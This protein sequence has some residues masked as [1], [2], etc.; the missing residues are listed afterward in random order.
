MQSISG[1]AEAVSHPQA[2]I[3]TLRAFKNTLAS[4]PALWIGFACICAWPWSCTSATLVHSDAIAIGSPLWYGSNFT[5]LIIGLAGFAIALNPV[6]LNK[7][8]LVYSIPL[9]AACCYS[10]ASSIFV[11]LCKL[12]SNQLL[13]DYA[14]MTILWPFL[15]GVGQII[16]FVSWVD[17]FGR[18]GSR[19]T[20]ALVVLGSLFGTGMLYGLNSMPQPV[21]E[22]A[23]LVM[24]LVASLCA[25]FSYKVPDCSHLEQPNCRG[26]KD[27]ADASQYSQRPMLRPPWKLLI[28]TLAAGFSFGIFQSISFS[29]GFGSGA[30]YDFGVMGF[31]LA[32]LLFALC[33]MPLKMNFNHLIYRVSFVLMALGALLCIVLPENAAWGY[34]VFCVGYRFFDVLIWCL[35]AYLVHH[36][37]APSTWLGGLCM[38]MLLLGR[39]IGFET[40]GLWDALFST[41]PL[42]VLLALVLFGLMFI[43]LYLV[44]QTN[45][46]EA[47]GMAQPG[48]AEDE[49]NLVSY[50]CAQI[51]Q[52]YGLSARE[53]D[54]LV[55]LAY[56]KSRFEVSQALV[57]SEETIKTHIR[58][59]YQKLDIHSRK[60]LDQL[61]VSHKQD[62]RSGSTTFET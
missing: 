3:N 8:S 59:L 47:W 25:Y 23:P 57:L 6:R 38:G 55:Q 26:A 19:K 16:L 24:G 45:L 21:R 61:L 17:A 28:T 43:A 36:H 4:Y 10:A 52:T 34:E 32:A 49:A 35:C 39:F 40:F 2:L 60:E 53:Q 37:T 50:C 12:P 31:F 9:I 41:Q 15:A 18:L 33:A 29:G 27:E 58:H 62:A 1:K 20:V 51:A 5:Y 11:A 7:R 42:S 13:S 56:G 22:L 14:A 48:E 46:R 54:V 44:S 30:W